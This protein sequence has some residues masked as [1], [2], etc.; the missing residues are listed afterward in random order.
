MTLFVICHQDLPAYPLPAGAQIVWMNAAPPPAVEDSAF[1]RGYDLFENGASL[2]DRLS[3][4]LGSAAI[5]RHVAGLADRPSTVTIWQYRKFVTRTQFGR[6]SPNYSGMRLLTSDE[7]AVADPA[8]DLGRGADTLAVSPLSMGSMIRQYQRHHHLVDLLRYV[9]TAIDLGVVTQAEALAF[10]EGTHLIPGGLELG[11]YETT[12]WLVDFEAMF[13]V[14]MAFIE[15]FEPYAT[16]DAYQR[17]AVSFCQERL[18]SFLL[19]NRLRRD[20]PKGL[21]AS[22]FGTM[23]TIT[24]EAVYRG[25]GS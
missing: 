22:L 5:A 10:L 7:A 19:L 4:S 6:P 12:A 11:T 16:T 24:S 3:G 21:P 13:K 14:G 17:R 2:H 20:Y 18:G 25:G 8:S 23:H 1:V 15:R 9:T